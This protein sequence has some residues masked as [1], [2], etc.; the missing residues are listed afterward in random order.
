[1]LRRP[2]QPDQAQTGD[3][4]KRFWFKTAAKPPRN[5]RAKGLNPHTHLLHPLAGLGQ[6]HEWGAHGHHLLLALV[7]PLLLLLALV[8]LL[9]L[10]L[11]LRQLL[12][13]VRQRGRRRHSLHRRHHP[14][15]LLLLL[16]PQPLP[17]AGV[18]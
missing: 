2:Q 9:L 12:V 15:L 11:L 4:K 13:V 1:M 14:Q 8:A 10:S 16:L 7:L 5:P 6:S 3:K 18:S 17:A